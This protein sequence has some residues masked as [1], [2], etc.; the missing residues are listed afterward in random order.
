MKQCSKCKELKEERLFSKDASKPSGFRSECKV[1]LGSRRRARYNTPE[2]TSL[3]N[4]KAYKEKHNRE[5]KVYRSKHQEKTKAQRACSHAGMTCVSLRAHH[6]SYSEQFWH[7]IIYMTPQQH[8][9]SHIHLV[10]SK[11]HMLFAALDGD[12][13]TTKQD[14]LDYLHRCKSLGP[15]YEEVSTVRPDYL[16]TGGYTHKITEV[17]FINK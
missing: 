8:T 9:E 6:W 2:A 4:S 11:E 15:S 10:Y 7:D 13:L 17:E 12:L 3:R 1:C 14:H 5:S 16:G